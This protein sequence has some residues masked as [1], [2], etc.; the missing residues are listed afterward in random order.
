M[1]YK[2]SSSAWNCV[3]ICVCMCVRTCAYSI[4]MK[5]FRGSTRNFD[6][7][8]LRLL[9]WM[10]FCNFDGRHFRRRRVLM[11]FCSCLVL[12]LLSSCCE[13]ET[14]Q[15]SIRSIFTLNL[16]YNLNKLS[17]IYPKSYFVL[18]DSYF[19]EFMYWFAAVGFMAVVINSAL[20]TMNCF[21]ATY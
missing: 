18:N 20:F 5:L 13:E 11:V 4:D 6:G 14:L 8:E 7:A 17:I 16:I 15:C 9:G 2:S 12:I 3:N 1:I 10:V 21:M 19:K